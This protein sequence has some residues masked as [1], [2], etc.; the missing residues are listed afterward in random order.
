MGYI[1]FDT[2]HDGKVALATDEISCI[3]TEVKEGK[4]VTMIFTKGGDDSYWYSKNDFND[5]LAQWSG[6]K[7]Q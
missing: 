3:T 5:L 2:P 7:N 4:I 6:S 1:V